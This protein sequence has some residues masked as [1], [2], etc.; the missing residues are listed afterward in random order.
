MPCTPTGGLSHSYISRWVDLTVPSVDTPPTLDPIPSPA[1]GRGRQRRSRKDENDGEESRRSQ[2]TCSPHPPMTRLAP[3]N[4]RTR[5]MTT[6]RPAALP[7]PTLSFRRLAHQKQP[8]T[9]QIIPRVPSDVTN[10]PTN[11][12]PDLIFMMSPVLGLDT[13]R[14]SHLSAELDVGSWVQTTKS[15]YIIVLIQF[16]VLLVHAPHAVY[17]PVM[18]LIPVLI[19]PVRMSL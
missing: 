16:A 5:V 8:P 13:R 15:L 19:D 7:N 12:S 2:A 1:R 17:L 9:T 4:P 6:R 11:P 18:L 3:C 10:K 14:P